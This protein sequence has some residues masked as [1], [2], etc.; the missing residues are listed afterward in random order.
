MTSSHTGVLTALTMPIGARLLV[1]HVSEADRHN[2]QVPIPAREYREGDFWADARCRECPARS[3][4]GCLGADA[5][6]LVIHRDDCPQLA[7]IRA[8]VPR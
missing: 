1:G 5:L 4:L 6:T 3:E 7:A 2:L 8:M